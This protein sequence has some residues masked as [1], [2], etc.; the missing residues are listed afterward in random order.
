MG[1]PLGRA[2]FP[3]GRYVEVYL[4]RILWHTNASNQ[5]GAVAHRLSASG[6]CATRSGRRGPQSHRDRA[7][8]PPN[9]I[10]VLR[11]DE[12]RLTGGVSKTSLGRSDMGSRNDLSPSCRHVS[13]CRRLGQIDPASLRATEDVKQQRFLRLEELG[14]GGGEYPREDLDLDVP[15]A[16]TKSDQTHA[17]QG[18]TIVGAAL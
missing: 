9:P 16:G 15:R 8:G 4:S 5:P 3:A 2:D 1:D 17:R 10:S 18:V 13:R 6:S 11:R 7:G 12:Q 14:G